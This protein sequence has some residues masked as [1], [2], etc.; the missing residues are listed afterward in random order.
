M[1]ISAAPECSSKLPDDARQRAFEVSITQAES[2]L[3]LAPSSPTMVHHG[4]IEGRI[5][6]DSFTADLAYDDYYLSYVLLDHA[7]STD[8]SPI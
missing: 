4:P 1:T 8:W 6:A 3:T 2:H 7:S 5:F